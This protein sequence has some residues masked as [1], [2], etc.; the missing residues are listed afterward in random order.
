MSRRAAN[1]S[2]QKRT[3]RSRLTGRTSWRPGSFTGWLQQV[4]FSAPRVGK[5]HDESIGL[6]A[7]RFQEIDAAPKQSLIVGP[8]VPRVKEKADPSSRL[9]ADTGALTVVA[10]NGEHQRGACAR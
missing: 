8:E 5:D 2:P 3:W 7:R 9:V 6:A 4:P 10:R 1:P